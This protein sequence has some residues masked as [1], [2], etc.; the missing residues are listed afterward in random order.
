[1]N[2]ENV[3]LGYALNAPLEEAQQVG[4]VPD[5]DSTGSLNAVLNGDTL[6]I[7]GSFR[8]LT[9]DLTAIRLHMGEAGEDGDSIEDLTVTNN[10]D[11]SG[12][13]IGRFEL[14][15]AE[16]ETAFNDGL[17]INLSTEDNPDGELR[18]QIE[19]NLRDQVPLDPTTVQDEGMGRIDLRD[20]GEDQFVEF[21]FKIT[22]EADFDNFSDFY[23]ADENGNAIDPMTG[24]AIAPGEEGYLET[25]LKSRLGFNF[26]VPDDSEDTVTKIMP[27]GFNYAPMIVVNGTF[28]EL[29]DDDPSN[30]PEVYFP[31]PEANSDGVEHIRNMGDMKFGFE[32]L[33]GGGDEDF[34]DITFEAF[35]I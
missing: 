30:D 31:Y 8:N 33:P 35:E 27:G 24:N 29:T 6:T 13:F 5:T 25:A 14:N 7:T 11:G 4:E 3:K 34:N 1:M 21:E 18:G 9:S 22:R 23:I 28:D 17:Y 20:L 15:E 26:S 12:S 2:N 19:L 32:D 16:I 10:G